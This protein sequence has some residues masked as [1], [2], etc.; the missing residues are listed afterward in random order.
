[1]EWVA[2]SYQAVM[3]EVDISNTFIKV[4]LNLSLQSANDSTSTS[5][6][7]M[8]K[9]LHLAHLSTTRYSKFRGSEDT[10]G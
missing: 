3:D 4:R 8:M 10:G 7:P 5:S 2:Q 6:L 1:M 9:V